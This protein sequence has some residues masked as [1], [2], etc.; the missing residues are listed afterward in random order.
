V[1][2]FCEALHCG[3]L[4]RRERVDWWVFGARGMLDNGWCSF[5]LKIL[6]LD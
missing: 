6:V 2:F 3:L 4:G 1:I 5:F